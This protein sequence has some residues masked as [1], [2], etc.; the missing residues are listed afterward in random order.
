MVVY[1]IDT[2]VVFRAFQYYGLYENIIWSQINYLKRVESKRN[3][4]RAKHSFRIS[5]AQCLKCLSIPS[6]IMS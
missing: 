5:T 2:S 3:C 4:C 1:V 6:V